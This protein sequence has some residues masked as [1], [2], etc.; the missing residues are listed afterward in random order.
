MNFD[1]IEHYG[2]QGM[3]W[4]VRNEYKPSRSERKRQKAHYKKTKVEAKRDIKEMQALEK[5]QYGSQKWEEAAV[6][7]LNRVES[8][9]VYRKAVMGQARKQAFARATVTTG[10]VFLG[11]TL[12][13]NV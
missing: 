9:A 7:G 6:K 12:L 8:D 11:L 10:A 5:Y 1:H 4:G 3:R 13:R 2:V